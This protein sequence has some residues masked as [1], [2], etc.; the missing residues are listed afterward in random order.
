[1]VGRALVRRLSSPDTTILMADRQALDLRDPAAVRRWLTMERPDAIVIAAAT[2][3]G[4]GDNAARPA[5][6]LYDNLMI[7]ANIIHAAHESDVGRLLFLGSSCIYPRDAAQPIAED[8]LLT[9]VLEPTNEAYAIAKIAGIKLCQAYRKQY[10]RT[11]I[12]AMPC[13]LYG[14][15]DRFD[16]FRSHVIPALIVKMH[17]A[18]EDRA[19]SVNLWGTGT[20]LREFLHVDDLADALATLLE[21]YDGV[22]PVNVGGGD[23]VSIHK[24]AQM[25][26]K[27]AGFEG[28]ILFDP[29]MPDGTPR[30]MM[31]S[32]MMR[33]MGWAP[34]IALEDGLRNSHDW[35]VRHIVQARKAAA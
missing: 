2:V 9:G 10:G 4:I 23:E 3:G 25:V 5:D 7:A 24:L 13:N 1:M 20:P 21:H 12:S 18:K 16:A 28:Q 35:Y 14:P 26:A 31:D 6:F 32:T 34:R 30:K 29:S 33:S 8:A 11:Y 15:Y 22:S 19:A 27:A 17:Q